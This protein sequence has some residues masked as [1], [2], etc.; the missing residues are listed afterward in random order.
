[1]TTAF[2]N[3]S[4]KKQRDIVI[5]VDGTEDTQKDVAA[6]EDQSRDGEPVSHD[7]SLSLM[8]FILCYY[9]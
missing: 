3:P 1:M 7:G 2:V 6:D 4:T 5:I 8:R 9:L